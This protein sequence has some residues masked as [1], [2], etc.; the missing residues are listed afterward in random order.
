MSPIAPDVFQS[1]QKLDEDE[2]PAI[3]TEMNSISMLAN[4]TWFDIPFNLPFSVLHMPEISA[5][6]VI[7]VTL[8]VR[9]K[10]SVYINKSLMAASRNLEI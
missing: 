8:S 2:K 1:I 4:N 7:E 9:A 3:S 5:V 6:I 10:L